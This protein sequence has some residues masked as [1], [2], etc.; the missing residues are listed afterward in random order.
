M[1]L[2]SPSISFLER[3]EHQLAND[4]TLNC[5]S[6]ILVWDRY[7]KL[8]LKK[9]IQ[10]KAS[11]KADVSYVQTSSL[12]GPTQT[13]YCNNQL[14]ILE[15]KSMVSH[16]H[17]FECHHSAVWFQSK[18]EFM[19]IQKCPEPSKSTSLMWNSVDDP[20]AYTFKQ[21]SP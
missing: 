3:T 2:I 15:Q 16:H 20:C 13:L 19:T 14:T 8:S 10:L 4:I 17:K 11:V 6:W 7:C 12:A 21:Q 18:P 9:N 1:L 5:I